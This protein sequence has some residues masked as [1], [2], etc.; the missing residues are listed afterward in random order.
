MVDVHPV[1]CQLSQDGERLAVGARDSAMLVDTSS[2]EVTELD[3]VATNSTVCDWAFSR[4]SE[5][6]AGVAVNGDVLLWDFASGQIVWKRHLDESAGV[7]FSEDSERLFVVNCSGV[8]KCF[9]RVGEHLATRDLGACARLIRIPMGVCAVCLKPS[10]LELTCLSGSPRMAETTT[11]HV[12]CLRQPSS[13]AA[14][15]TNIV[16]SLTGNNGDSCLELRDQ[17][18]LS[19]M[20]TAL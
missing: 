10:G 8:V 13:F 1:S 14:N 19:E 5:W 11:A 16:M 2:G 18:K 15:R 4:N 9:S 7:E 3:G 12:P 6:L 17:D 20:T